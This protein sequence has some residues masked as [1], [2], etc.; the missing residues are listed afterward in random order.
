[1][2]GHGYWTGVV[3]GA[4]GLIYG[5]AMM[6]GTNAKGVVFRM[7]KDGASYTVLHH[8]DGTDGDGTGTNNVP[9]ARLVAHSDGNFYGAMP[10]GGASDGGT[11]FKLTPAG[12]FTKLRDFG[13]SSP[14]G[15]A[16]SAG[17]LLVTTSTSNTRGVLFDVTTAGATTVIYAF[18][19]AFG[20]KPVGAPLLASDG[21]IYGTTTEGGTND[22][23]TL[24]RKKS[25]G[26][27]DVLASFSSF[28]RPGA[29]L[30]EG[31]DGLLYSA[32]DTDV[33]SATKAGKLTRLSGVF[34]N[35]GVVE[36][37]DGA[38]YCVGG[39]RLWRTP[40][41]G[42]S[43]SL[44]IFS[45]GD[46]TGGYGP[47][48][49]GDDG[50]LYG[51]TTAG[52]AN[53]SGT[54]WKFVG[55]VGGTFSVVRNFQATEKPHGPLVKGLDG[56]FYGLLFNNGIATH[57]RITSTGQIT[58]L[59]ATAALATD[60]TPAQ[61][62]LAERNLGKF[63]VPHFLAPT[64][65]GTVR[66]LFEFSSAAAPFLALAP[67]P[68]TTVTPVLGGISRGPDKNL[69][70]VL[71]DGA[72]N[73]GSL[74]RIVM[75]ANGDPVPGAVT[76]AATNVQSLSATLNGEV[77]P[78][79]T[80]ALVYFEYGATTAY[81]KRTPGVL[82]Q[83]S[84]TATVAF[85]A[86][87]TGLVRN[88]VFH[89]RIV[90]END[91]GTALGADQSTTTTS[92][93]APLAVTDTAPIRAKEVLTIS[94]LAN[95]S[96][97]DGDAFTL[98]SFTQGTKGVVTRVGNNLIYTPGKTFAGSDTFTY[99][100]SDTLAAQSVGQVI[101]QNPFLSLA[102][103]YSPLV[104]DDDGMLTLK[105]TT[106]GALTGKLQLGAKKFSLKGIIALNGTYSQ[107]IKRKGLADLVVTLNFTNPNQLATVTGTVD[108]LPVSDAKLA[109]TLPAPAVA[110]KYTAVLHPEAATIPTSLN[111]YGWAKG[112]LST[113][114]ALSLAG[115]TPDG[116]A[117]SLG[118][119]MRV[120]TSVV[121][122][123]PGKA[124]GASFIGKL[125]FANAADSDFSG[126]LRWTRGVQTKGIFL[127]AID[128]T[129]TLQ[130]CQFT[131]PAKLI[132]TLT[133][134]APNA[135]S[136][137]LLLSL[138]VPVTQNFNVDLKDK[139]LLIPAQLNPELLAKITLIH[140]ADGRFEGTFKHP[141]LLP[142]AKPIKFRGVQLQ[143]ALGGTGPN[144]AFGSFT[145][146]TAA[147]N[148]TFTPL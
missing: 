16:E 25:T 129:F 115:V 63:Y 13:E 135:A 107:I 80:P 58:T 88:A 144:K 110:A 109:T 101:V 41:T 48:A 82:V 147:G 130:G 45:G 2:T 119:K 128:T 27:F 64:G 93:S 5:T 127:G 104:G 92:N 79:G 21:H 57:Y 75:P 26:E 106:G 6:G 40:K 20:S 8:F 4:D 133:Y 72:A 143:T 67:S 98:D 43:E 38:L 85:S 50:A 73:L 10:F 62:P 65:A 11:L 32:T 61:F 117:F 24:W 35:N 95:D 99:T 140:R 12:V 15:L 28:T 122:F 36:G 23:G 78:N 71:P 76:L 54:M 3:E 90:A 22:L 131:P 123:K 44:R 55:A 29:G 125:S 146:P 9:K 53:G 113:K 105:V 89:F 49:L 108:G 60:G 111:A 42:M 138:A 33:F 68:A 132:H 112:K 116:K 84:A 124:P 136:G 83:P 17:K 97:P 51:V 145:I 137:A 31:T 52:A 81:G 148:F 77:T 94:V 37:S 103:S 96:D 118:G 100:L 14:G 87:A 142:T 46:G 47:P 126:T 74:Y 114:G 134:S 121:F 39:G 30:I 66:N 120:D 7:G 56:A 139:A 18:N 59:G 70:G 69:Y 141:A 19:D 34:S 86:Q 1:M 91:G 102:G